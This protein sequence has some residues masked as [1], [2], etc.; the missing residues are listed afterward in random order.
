M[1]SGPAR[2]TSLGGELRRAWLQIRVVMP[3]SK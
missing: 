3:L 1:G 2:F